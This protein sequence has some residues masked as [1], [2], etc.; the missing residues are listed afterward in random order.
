MPIQ[1][2][3]FRYAP[4]ALVMPVL[5]GC[6]S[7][8]GGTIASTP[9]PYATLA[10]G[11]GTL[12]AT[13]GQL[14]YARAANAATPT[15]S[16]FTPD[17][18]ISYNAS[19]QTYTLSAVTTAGSTQ[20]TTASYGPAQIDTTIGLSG[21]YNATTR[22]NGVTTV[23]TLQVHQTT[24]LT[25]SDIGLWTTGSTQAD[26]TQNFNEIYFSYGIRTLPADLPKTGSASYGLALVG[27][28]GGTNVGGTG[29]LSANFAVGTVSVSLSPEY[30]YAQGR[31]PFGPITGTGTI[32]SATST[33]SGTLASSAYTGSVNGAFYGPQA[34]EAGGSFVINSA[35]GGGVVA[36]GAFAGKRN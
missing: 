7:D 22:I 2:F 5:C 19:T 20:P 27:D 6:A 32:S 28:G 8:G 15:Y 36:A 18:T 11:T 23:S 24:A 26:F 29:T 21:A 13:A 17:L 35:T 9:A 33:F 12:S 4:V 16:A 30:I 25:Y 34:A 31:S 1:W 14:N 10:S 3:R